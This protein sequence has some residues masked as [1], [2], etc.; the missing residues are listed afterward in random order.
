MENNNEYKSKRQVKAKELISK[1][2]KHSLTGRDLF[3][4]RDWYRIN[5]LMIYYTSDEEAIMFS[6]L[7]E[8]ENKWIA[9]RNGFMR[10]LDGYFLLTIEYVSKFLNKSPDQQRRSLKKLETLGVISIKYWSG[11]KRIIKINW[12]CFDKKYIEWVSLYN[13]LEIKDPFEEMSD[14]YDKLEQ[15]S[16]LN[17]LEEDLPDYI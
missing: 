7:C 16:G 14:N 5:R 11:K 1:I 6:L 17:I 10:K 3:N 2:E 8:V 9:K 4:N 15:G 12:N 13:E